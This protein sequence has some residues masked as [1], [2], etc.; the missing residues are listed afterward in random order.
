[1]GGGMYSKCVFGTLPFHHPLAPAPDF[2]NLESSEGAQISFLGLISL[3]YLFHPS[4]SSVN[5][6]FYF[7]PLESAFYLELIKNYF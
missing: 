2:L 1:M 6:C 4:F 3:T 7:I 5:T